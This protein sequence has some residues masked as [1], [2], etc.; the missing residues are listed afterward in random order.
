MERVL[1]TAP[2]YT[3]DDLEA[4]ADAWG[5]NCSP[6]SA[7]AVLGFTLDEVRDLFTVAGFDPKRYTNPT[8]MVAVLNAV[9]RQ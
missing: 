3:A 2:R 1:V 9:G 5:C 4:A 7:A 6:G 8:M